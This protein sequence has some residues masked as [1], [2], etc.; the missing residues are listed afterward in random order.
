VSRID[1]VNVANAQPEAVE[2]LEAVKK[3]MGRVPN[4]LG[5]MVN[6]PAAAKSYLG[7][8][9]ALSHGRLPAKLRELVALTVGEANACDYCLAAHSA[10]GKMVGLSPDQILG[11]RRGRSEDPKIAAALEFVRKVVDSRG[12]VSDAD[13]AAVKTAGYTDGDV[14][15]LVANTALNLFTN[16][17]NHVADTPVDFPAAAPLGN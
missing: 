7:F 15:E 4:L 2:V 12:K 8:S 5:A 3:K 14:A 9:D 6:S 1:I 11:G 10:I 16:Y 13:V 17:F